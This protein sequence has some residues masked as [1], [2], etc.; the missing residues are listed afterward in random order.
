MRIRLKSSAARSPARRLSGLLGGL[1]M[2]FLAASLGGGQLVMDPI[3]QLFIP[4]RS[5]RP[6]SPAAVQTA[7]SGATPLVIPAA[8]FSGDGFSQNS[9]YFDFAQGYV[10]GG[11]VLDSGCLKAPVYL[12]EQAQ[13][14][15]MVAAVVDD[16]AFRGLFVTLYRVN[17]FTGGVDILANV[18]TGTS[19]QSA[20]IR[21][22]RDFTINQ[23]RIQH[24]DFSYYLYTC[25][26]SP[27][28]RLYSVRIGFGI[29]VYIPLLSR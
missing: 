8:D 29:P 27:A 28:I 9:H 3:A 26:V 18:S 1:V 19:D 24:P 22:L 23:P 21:Q 5:P 15:E 6:A 11:Q 7:F 13:V 10:R 20:E 2:V 17:N 14:V 12:P 4:V 16:D 25:M